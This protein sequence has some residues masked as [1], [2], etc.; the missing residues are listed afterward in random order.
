MGRST[1][2]AAKRGVFAKKVRGRNGDNAEFCLNRF[3]DDDPVNC[4][5]VL[6]SREGVQKK[7][8]S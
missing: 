3:S 7:H 6:Y 4:L 8:N 2:T 1:F 5:Q